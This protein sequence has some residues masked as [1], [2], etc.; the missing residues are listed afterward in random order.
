MM[1]RNSPEKTLFV[2]MRENYMYRTFSYAN[3]GSATT[4]DSGG[5]RKLFLL[6][7]VKQ[8]RGVLQKT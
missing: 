8:L 7:I 6:L 5:G 4:D 1:M 2:N 3:G